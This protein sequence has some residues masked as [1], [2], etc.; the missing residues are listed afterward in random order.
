MSELIRIAPFVALSF[1]LGISATIAGALIS[2]LFLFQ[3]GAQQLPLLY[4][5]SPFVVILVSAGLMRLIAC[6]PISKIYCF[7]FLL[8]FLLFVICEGAIA[9]QFK[10]AY[11]LLLFFADTLPLITWVVLF[12]AFIPQYFT[13]LELKRYSATLSFGN[14]LGSLLGGGL[15]VLS[16]NWF[17][18]Q[19]QVW[20]VPLFYV[21]HILQII[22][23]HKNQQLVSV[24]PVEEAPVEDA[25]D[26]WGSNLKQL[27]DL[28]VRFPLVRYLTCSTFLIWMFYYLCDYLITATYERS[29]SDEDALTRFLGTVYVGQNLLEI[30]LLGIAVPMLIQRV[31]VAGMN[32]VYPL[33]NLLCLGAFIICP[34]VVTAVVLRFSTNSLYQVIAEPLNAL[35]YK[36][37]PDHFAKQVRVVLEGMVAP[38][39]SVL[40]GGLLLVLQPFGNFSLAQFIALGAT[41]IATVVGY[42]LSRAMGD[43]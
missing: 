42:Q 27:Y 16:S 41:A 21:V 13:F 5:L 28:T 18:A 34:G 29:F 6:W 8:A 14:S 39:G 43:W 26:H 24:A 40:A 23:I 38:M 30:V 4:I 10:F 12:W 20:I 17:S 2:S 31:G 33:S 7:V 32:L 11:L 35:N 15:V 1:T 25:P 19:L 37:V 3:M 36:A 22:W 9:A